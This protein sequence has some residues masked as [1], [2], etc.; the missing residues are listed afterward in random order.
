M[1]SDGLDAEQVAVGQRPAGLARLDRVVVAGAHDQVTARG[2]GAVGDP[3]GG[4]GAD[5]A[6]AAAYNVLFLLLLPLLL[7]WGSCVWWSL[8]TGRPVP[9]ARV[10]PW[11]F[12]V[13]L[14]VV[15]AFWVLRNLPFP[16]FNLL[17][18]HALSGG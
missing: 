4:A 11:V 16:P 5:L 10:P 3:Y 15:F 12:R 8:W 14:V 13:L 2:P 18:P 1:G 9:G 6:Q 7:V 17:A